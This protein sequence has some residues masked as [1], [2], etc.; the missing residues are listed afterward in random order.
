M[1]AP[2]TTPQYTPPPMAQAIPAPQIKTKTP[3]DSELAA[4]WVAQNKNAAYGL[5]EWRKYAD[6]VWLPV[7]RDVIKQEM[8][9]VLDRARL[10]GVRPSAGQLA[11]VMELSR[12]DV[13]IP[14]D[15]WDANTEY[16]PCANGIY[17][18]PRKRYSHTHRI[19]SQPHGLILTMTPQQ[20]AQ[21]FYTRLK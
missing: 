10:D 3:D 9:S 1:T 17:T 13:A 8:K 7:D 19:F 15:R 21:T 16:L 14:A 20:R 12:I 4:R 5:G 6:G 18:S 2:N 11:S